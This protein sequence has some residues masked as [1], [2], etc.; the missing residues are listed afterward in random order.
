MVENDRVMEEKN[1]FFEELEEE[2]DLAG[3]EN[4]NVYLKGDRFNIMASKYFMSEIMI[5]LE[6][7]YDEKAFEM[8]FESGKLYGEDLLDLIGEEEEFSSSLGKM[9]GLLKFLGYSDSYMEMESV[10]FESTPTAEAYMEN[11]MFSRKACYFLAG[12][13]SSVCDRHEKD[14][15]FREQTCEAEEE[16]NDCV[17]V[18]V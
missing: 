2:E 5:I 17:F 10:V 3:D 13:L 7:A 9:L 8:L 18:M 4:G 1:R 15:E 14:K 12:I 16:G 6:D 11:Q